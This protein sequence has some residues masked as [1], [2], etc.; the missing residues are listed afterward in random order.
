MP[1]N[2]NMTS[3]IKTT[4]RPFASIRLMPARITAVVELDFYP[5]VS[6]SP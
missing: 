1:A 4:A 5:A 3:P 6:T 2:D